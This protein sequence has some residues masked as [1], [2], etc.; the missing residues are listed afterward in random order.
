MEVGV[1]V[2]WDMGE[3]PADGA[4]LD[5]DLDVRY[6]GEV[7]DASTKLQN[8]KNR[9]KAPTCN[10]RAGCGVEVNGS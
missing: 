6:N 8:G 1:A 3:F 5:S 7:L 2:G 4:V 9:A 10:G